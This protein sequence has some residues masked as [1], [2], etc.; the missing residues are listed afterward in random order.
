MIPAG[1]QSY[2]YIGTIYHPARLAR[3]CGKRAS[4][5]PS[6]STFSEQTA[7]AGS[8]KLVEQCF[9]LFEIGGSEALGE[10][11]VDRRE[12]VARFDAPSPVSP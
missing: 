11:A 6:S 9:C 5:E 2:R 8:G 7:K 12:K 4:P 3:Y 10:P 1:K